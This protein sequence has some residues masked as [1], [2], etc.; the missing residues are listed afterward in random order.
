MNLIRSRRIASAV[1]SLLAATSLC[2]AR[3]IDDSIRSRQLE[4]VIV[5][6]QSARQ[7]LAKIG[8]GVENIEL[9]TI[10]KMPMLFGE[11]DIIKSLALLPGVRAE[12]D[13]AGG[14]EV[15]GGN[16]SQ[17][18]IMLDGMTLYN[19][20]HVLGIFSTF[21][22]KALSRATL[23]KGPIPSE[24]GGATSSV[25]ETTLAHGDMDRYHASGTIGLLA[26]KIMGSGPLIIDK[27]SL[28]VSARRSYVDAFLQMVP[29]YRGTVM[30]F[31]D[32]TAKL[33]YIPRGGDYL[34][35]SFNI[36]HDNMAIKRVMGLY[37]GNLGAS[38]NWRAQRWG[39][40]T[41]I[42]TGSYTNYAPK[43]TMSA[44]NVDQ[45]LKEF[46]HD[47][48]FNEKVRIDVGDAQAFEMGIRTELLSVKSAE[49]EV[50]GN[51]EKEIR[52]G[53]Q[54]AA[55]VNYESEFA[56]HFALSAGVRFSL[57]SAISGKRFHEFSSSSESAPD[58]RSHT[59]FT[60]EPRINLKYSI[61]PYH[62]VRLGYSMSS[63]NL[64]SI[65]SSST[66]FPFDRYAITSATVRPEKATQY[67]V[68][69][70]G[71]TSNGDFDWSAEGYYKSLSNVYDYADG[72][73]M[74]SRINI[75]SII[76]G[77]RG[78]SYGAEFMFRKNT[79]PL[80][81]WVSYTISKTQT[82][83][84]GIN[85]GRWY[86]ATN[87]RRHDIAV[88]A[89]YSPDDRWSF[90]GSWIFTSGQPLTAPDVKYQ[91]DGITYYYY[92]ERNGYRTPPIHRLDLSA[93]YTKK[94][95]RFTT[96]WSFGLYNA[97]CRYNPDILRR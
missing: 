53:W 48:S 65:R 22:D 20:S 42:T 66:S 94:G 13:G 29:Q 92:S 77:G 31:Y 89:I 2:Q 90:S 83:I 38:L 67:G 78:R 97:Y 35:L 12:G 14:Y 5:T 11:N 82:R 80:T 63:Q 52:S 84:P 4:E 40:V 25:L 17:N 23:H 81:G 27:L 59:Y 36:G 46:I 86:D 28:A 61:S 58:F 1:M 8:L 3:E 75:E 49:V 41:F 18:L 47:Y 44:M 95:R 19:P 50:A 7:R 16:S 62:N 71:M 76:L 72:R 85:D 56:G 54:N 88:M 69:Y 87:D 32:V 51:L 10:V 57:F 43:M 37:W 73:T 39:N 24:Y 64:H 68:G 60:P 21:N 79:G 70:A 15:R 93:T 91:L 74:F 9:S 33:R 30:N 34:D 45:T 55:W 26:A 96:Q 6:S